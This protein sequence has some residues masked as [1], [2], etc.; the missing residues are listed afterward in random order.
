MKDECL[1]KWDI[2]TAKRVMLSFDLTLA[3][4]SLIF[5]MRASFG[6]INGARSH[7]LDGHQP[8]Q[9]L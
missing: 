9:L 1:L 3:N 8:Q 6:L 5:V 7:D 4:Q 2:M